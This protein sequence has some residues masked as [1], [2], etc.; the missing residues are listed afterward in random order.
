MH[1]LQHSTSRLHI[2]ALAPYRKPIC[3]ILV[4]TLA[5]LSGCS[6]TGDG[7]EEHKD[8]SAEKLYKSAKAEMKAGDYELAIEYLENR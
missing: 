6:S 1:Y 8:W 3:F 2:T 7:S 4:I 5:L